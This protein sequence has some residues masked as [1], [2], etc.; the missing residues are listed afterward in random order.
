MKYYFITYSYSLEEASGIGS[1]YV[2]T[3]GNCFDLKG[4]QEVLKQNIS[5]ENRGEC[6][7]VIINYYREVSKKEYDFNVHA[8]KN[9]N[10]IN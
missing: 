7:W 5:K 8:C 2:L 3:T 6:K 1:W 4:T 10:D 9:E